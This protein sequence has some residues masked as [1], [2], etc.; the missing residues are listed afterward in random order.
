MSS[1]RVCF[2]KRIEDS[3]GK[4]GNFIIRFEIK[5]KIDKIFEYSLIHQLLNHVERF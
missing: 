1:E 5:N 3:W 2:K 4:D